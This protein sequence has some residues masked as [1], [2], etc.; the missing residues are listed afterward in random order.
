M[1]ITIN[2]SKD[3]HKLSSQDKNRLAVQYEPLV[4]K[5]SKQFYDK[6]NVDW[7]SLKSMAYEGLALAFNTYDSTK[8]KMKFLNYAAY[9]IRN[10]ILTGIDNEIRTVKLSNYAQKRAVERGE[11]LFNSVS[12]S[13][14]MKSDVDDP[15][16]RISSREY[17][18][19]LYDTDKF[20]SG[21]P[22]EYLYNRLEEKFSPRDLDMFYKCFG[23][24]GYDNYK[25]KDIAKEY[26]VSEGLVSQKIKK[27]IT[28]IQKDNDLC[29]MLGSM[30]NN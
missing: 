6:T 19:R 28:F 8:S 17:K 15:H 12:M 26:E 4:N 5:I 2:N 13:D 25:N 30:L 7:S 3:Y 29:E 22:L 18:C 11:P 24:K 27:V 21:D 9:A 16:N 1:G 14:L 23:L 20:S 10:N